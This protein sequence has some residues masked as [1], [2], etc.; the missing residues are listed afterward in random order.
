MKQGSLVQW[1]NKPVFGIVGPAEAM[2]CLEIWVVD[3]SIVL[4]TPLFGPQ[5]VVRKENVRSTRCVY[6]SKDKL[7]EVKNWTLE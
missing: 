4:S 1:D 2:G 7:T 6:W 3:P 5:Y